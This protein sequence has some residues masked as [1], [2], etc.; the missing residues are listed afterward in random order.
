MFAKVPDAWIGV[1]E[2]DVLRDEGIMYGEALRKAGRT[3]E[4][5][6]YE[7]APHPIMANDQVGRL[8][9]SDVF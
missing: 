6:V 5:K 2:L 1:C 3:V 4:I 7:G 9:L 8:W